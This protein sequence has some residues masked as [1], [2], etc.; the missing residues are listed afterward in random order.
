MY[1]FVKVKVV[2]KLI[3]KSCLSSITAVEEY[4]ETLS[5]KLQ[6]DDAIYGNMLLAVVEAVTNAIEHGNAF[7][8]KK[9]VIFE[10]HQKGKYLMFFIKDQGAGFDPNAVPDPT[11][12]ENVEV[13]RGRGV[14]LIRNLAD[15]VQFVENGTGVKLEFA[16]T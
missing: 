6:I 9:K 1:N 10:V 2:G 13:P 15:S 14:F 5:R 3:F 16:L 4:I 7:D 11:L 8:E 12:P